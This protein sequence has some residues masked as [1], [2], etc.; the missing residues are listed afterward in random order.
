MIFEELIKEEV[1]NQDHIIQLKNS[2]NVKYP[3]DTPKQKARILAKEVFNIIENALPNY[4][5]ETKKSVRHFLLQ[6]NLVS[7]T[8]TITLNDIVDASFQVVEDNEVLKELPLWLETKSD[9]DLDDIEQFVS[10]QLEIRSNE[11]EVAAS[12][13]SNAL[14]QTVQAMPKEEFPSVKNSYVIAAIICFLI[15]IPL[16]QTID[17]QDSE[18]PQTISTEVTEVK[19]VVEEEVR[20]NNALPNKLQYQPINEDKLRA[21]LDGRDSLLGEEPYFS[22]IIAVADEFN[23]H[24]LL[25]FAI[26]GQEQAFVPKSHERAAEIANNPFNVFHSWQDFNTNIKESTEIAAR[27]IV[28]LSE[29]RPADVDPI[30][31]INRKYAEDPN[32][33]IG[34]SSIYEMLERKVKEG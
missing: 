22:T 10:A 28:N 4:S 25:L 12:A 17:M 14:T 29:D 24:P 7:H 19:N 5:N 8:L 3:H 32:W 27:T 30:K 34:V 18:V 11:R 31:W 23:I 9:F 20:L 33:W 15:A 26:T 1:I 6:Q 21:F 13:T 2:I 16:L